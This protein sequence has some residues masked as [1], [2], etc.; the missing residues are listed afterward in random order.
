[1][2]AIV[3]AFLAFGFF[4]AGLLS[5]LWLLTLTGAAA[6]LTFLIGA[7]QSM[8]LLRALGLAIAAFAISQV[9]YGVGLFR[10]AMLRKRPVPD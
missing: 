9:G 6:A 2:A 8:G 7:L 5:V 4:A 3:L 10:V 1:M